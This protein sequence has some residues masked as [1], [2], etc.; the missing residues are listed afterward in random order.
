[1]KTRSFRILGKNIISTF[2]HY[3]MSLTFSSDVKSNDILTMECITNCP[4]KMINGTYSV[5]TAKKL[6]LS[7]TGKCDVFIFRDH[8][9]NVIGTVSVMYK[10][11]NDIEYKVRN[12]D[13]FIYNVLTDKEYRGKGF[14]KEMICLLMEHL[15]SKSVEKVYLAVSTNNVAA[16]RA[17][18]KTGFIK[19][20]NS[21]FIRV[22]KVNIPYKVV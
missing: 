19:E 8:D 10:G 12:C 1:M 21:C 16:V 18:E 17:Y 6:L 13:A 14:A 11:G 5:E 20:Y 2:N 3:I 22:L 9:G 4:E 15:H 7:N